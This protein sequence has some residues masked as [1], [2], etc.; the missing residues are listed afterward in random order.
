VYGTPSA[1]LA[2][3]A[4]AR[5]AGTIPRGVFWP[6]PNVDSKLVSFTRHAQPAAGISRELVFAV[7]D[8]AFG[9]RRKTLRAALGTWAGSPAAAEAVLRAAGIDPGARGESLGIAEFA[10]IA[11]FAGA[12]AAAR[13]AEVTGNGEGAGNAEAPGDGTIHRS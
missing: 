5:P 3:Y 4:A 10:R 7:I 11:E 12:A 2:W 13:D 8:A 6:V 1:N 9:Q